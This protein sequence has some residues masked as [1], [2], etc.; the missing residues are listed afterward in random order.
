MRVGSGIMSKE[1]EIPERLVAI[2]LET[3]GLYAD[4]ADITELGAVRFE[5]DGKELDTFWE[6]ANPGDPIPPE[7]L[8]YTQVRDEMLRHAPPPAEILG[9]FVH[10]LRDDHWLVAH[11]G[12]FEGAFLE[13]GFS[14]IGKPVPQLWMVS[15]AEW[16]R[17]AKPGLPNYR[18]DTLANALDLMPNV[19]LGKPTLTGAST[20][21][22]LYLKLATS[23]SVNAEA[24]S[25][26]V[27]PQA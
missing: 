7:V 13:A 10:W 16:A 25:F 2:S 6:R 20:V 15:T 26:I 4:R 8:P 19:Y 17:K 9:R 5:A 21:K 1:L 22:S 11:S 14:K 23:S 24:I 18:L 27:R 3:T 12:K